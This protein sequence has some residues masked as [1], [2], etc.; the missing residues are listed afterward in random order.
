MHVIAPND[1]LYD[2]IVSNIQ[3]IKARGGTVIAIVTR[4]IRLCGI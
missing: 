3:Q 4:E 2:K 1:L